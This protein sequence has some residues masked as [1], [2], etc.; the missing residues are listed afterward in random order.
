MALEY[1]IVPKDEP[2]NYSVPRRLKKEYNAS[3]LCDHTALHTTLM[4]SSLYLD[5]P[6][7]P[8]SHITI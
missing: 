4:R 6:T 8:A 1:N 2:R 5:R 7:V 3:K